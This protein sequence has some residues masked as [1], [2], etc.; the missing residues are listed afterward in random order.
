MTS[1]LPLPIHYWQERADLAATGITQ[2]QQDQIRREFAKRRDKENP[3]WR[4]EYLKAVER[5]LYQK[6]GSP[7]VK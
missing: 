7:Y 4:E 6:N 1:P 5:W 2:D 3:N